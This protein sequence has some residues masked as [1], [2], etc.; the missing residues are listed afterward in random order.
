M[1]I[2]VILSHKWKKLPNINHAGDEQK[3]K[4]QT[5]LIQDETTIF[6]RFMICFSFV[7]NAPLLPMYPLL[8]HKQLSLS[9]INTIL[10]TIL[11]VTWSLQCYSVRLFCSILAKV[12]ESVYVNLS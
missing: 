3:V 8:L 5:K 7:M 6:H 1:G 2:L 12:E 10:H 9:F 11:L 4:K